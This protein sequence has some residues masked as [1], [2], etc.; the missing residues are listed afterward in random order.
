MLKALM[1]AIYPAAADEALPHRWLLSAF[2]FLN[3]PPP[4]SVL[5]RFITNPDFISP[6]TLYKMDKKNVDPFSTG[7]MPSVYN[8]FRNKKLILRIAYVTIIRKQAVWHLSLPQTRVLPP[9]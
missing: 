5:K 6:Q 9:F 4:N 3:T 7:P 2:Y 1:E 8:K